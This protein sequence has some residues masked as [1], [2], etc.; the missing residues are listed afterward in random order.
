MPEKTPETNPAGQEAE[1]LSK[2]DV[3][4]RMLSDM[5]GSA[6]NRQVADA[7]KE[8]F[9]LD[10]TVKYVNRVRT[11]SRKPATRPAA[12]AAKKPA[13]PKPAPAAAVPAA[14]SSNGAG[15]VSVRLEDVLAVQTLVSRVGGDHLRTLI[16]AFEAAGG[17]G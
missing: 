6:S 12:P 16:A 14:T 10:V 4:R 8:K 2:K 15:P 13:A 17:R 1:G 3:V 5:G 11:E 9:G 7:V